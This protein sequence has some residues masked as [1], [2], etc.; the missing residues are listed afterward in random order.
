MTGFAGVDIPTDGD[1]A[2]LGLGPDG[3]LGPGPL[4]EQSLLAGIAQQAW[5]DLRPQLKNTLTT[6]LGKGDLVGDGYT[7]YDIDVQLSPDV[8]QSTVQRTPEGDL[9]VNVVIGRSVVIAT[10]TTPTVFGS[11]ADPRFSL[12]FGVSLRYLVDVPPVAAPLSVTGFEDLRI[13]GPHA[14]SQNLP[15]DLVFLLVR[16]VELVTGFSLDGTL[17]ALLSQVD[18]AGAVNSRLD[19]VNAAV[20]RLAAA[21]YHYLELLAGDPPDLTRQLGPQARV[22]QV[23]QALT[24]DTQ[25]LLLVCRKPDTS[26]VIEGEVSWKDS[27]GGPISQVQRAILSSIAQPRVGAA[28]VTLALAAM[29]GDE[30]PDVVLD[31]PQPA[32]QRAILTTTAAGYAAAPVGADT[33]L[34]RVTGPGSMAVWDSAGAPPADLHQVDGPAAQ[35]AGARAMRTAAFEALVGGRAAYESITDVF[36]RGPQQFAVT[37]TAPD[38]AG[39]HATGHLVGS[40]WDDGDG[41]SRRRFRIEDVETDVPLNVTCALAPK[42]TWHPGTVQ[43]IAPRNWSGTVTVHPALPFG[44][45]LH[46]GLTQVTVSLADGQRRTVSIAALEEAGALKRPDGS[47]RSIIVVGGAPADE[48]MLNPQPLP[49]KVAEQLRQSLGTDKAIIVVGGRH[50]AGAV[51]HRAGLRNVLRWSRRHGAVGGLDLDQVAGG[52]GAAHTQVEGVG[53]A[54][55]AHAH[56]EGAGAGQLHGG[57]EGVAHAQTG[58][59]GAVRTQVDRFGDLHATD[60]DPDIFIPD[61]ENPTG[62][63]TVGGIDFRVFTD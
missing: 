11:W 1:L 43:E 51:W 62:H 28:G 50:G 26:G 8:L 35:G 17:A 47:E 30:A 9:A 6:K 60:I 39:G 22:G 31:G 42:W 32:L 7:L 5:D 41:W 14:D 53:A 21:G 10:S 25:S 37:C 15:G 13:T 48:V 52:V 2:V 55:A 27:Q 61:V 12:D 40:W 46:D 54:G 38:G 45:A 34:S 18:L 29:Q 59:A 4:S 49:P 33:Q 3:S 24:A 20:E 23:V 56:V 58:A 57:G 16:A 44:S 19:D 63:G 36:R